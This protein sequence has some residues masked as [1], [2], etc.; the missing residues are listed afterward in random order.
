MAKRT[1]VGKISN[2]GEF[3]HRGRVNPSGTEFWQSNGRELRGG[4]PFFAEDNPES[5]GNVA[6]IDLK[7]NKIK[8]KIRIGGNPHDVSFSPDGKHAFVAARQLPVRND[9]SVVVV[10]TETGAVLRSYPVCLPCHSA[11][12]VTIPRERDDSRAFLCAVDI[13]WRK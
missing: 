5:W 10:S 12:G 3:I 7:R 11:M 6:I 13:A 4:E 8:K 2:V 9:S 1:V